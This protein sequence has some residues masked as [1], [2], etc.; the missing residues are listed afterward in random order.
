YLMV[1]HPVSYHIH[2]TR[3][4]VMGGITFMW[5]FTIVLISSFVYPFSGVQD[6]ICIL[7]GF[8]PSVWVGWFCSVFYYTIYF[9]LPIG[10]FCICY[11]HALVIIRRRRTAVQSHGHST[12][13]HR[14]Q[15]NLT[16][17]M[18]AVSGA[19]ILCW[20]PVNTHY[21]LMFTEV[22]PHLNMTDALYRSLAYLSFINSC[23]NP[24]L[25]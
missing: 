9:F 15:V 23:I 5:L 21:L 12:V 1:A 18:I 10:M 13:M 6:G 7:Q 16:K 2:V 4:H 3:N 11:G 22:M 8:F 19:F 17:T 25:Y 24:I 14:N 20:A